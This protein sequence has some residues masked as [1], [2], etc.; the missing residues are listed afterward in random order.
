MY[1]QAL[2]SRV[3]RPLRQ[4]CAFQRVHVPAGEC[5]P[6]TL[7]VPQHALEFYDVTREKMVMEQGRY[8]FRVGA[9]SADIRLELELT[10]DGETD[11][12]TGSGRTGAVQELRHQVRHRY[13]AA[14]LQGTER[15]VRLHQ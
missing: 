3:K 10:L 13:N 5:C 4:L 8:A 11:S 9:S 15:L 14:I 1:A 6:V 2:T 12:V 7:F